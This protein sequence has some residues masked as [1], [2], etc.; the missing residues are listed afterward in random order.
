[1]GQAGIKPMDVLVATTSGAARALGCESRLGSVEVGKSADLL[2]L[3]ENP[4]DDLRRLG[5]K[6][7][8]RAV[9]LDGKLV[10]RQSV[11]SFP[12]TIFA[13]DC[14]TAGE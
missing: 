1:M 2:V 13:R 11:D 6:R 3:D 7:Q 4:L 9:F 14:L 5:D 10:A 12:K 8:I